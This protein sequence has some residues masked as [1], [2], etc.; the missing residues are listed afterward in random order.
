MVLLVPKCK[1]QAY[2]YVDKAN[3]RVPDKPYVP[4]SVT[5]GYDIVHVTFPRSLTFINQQSIR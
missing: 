1:M 2:I 4:C 5:M 3:D